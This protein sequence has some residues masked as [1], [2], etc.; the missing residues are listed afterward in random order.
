MEI[1]KK[2][3]E[4][5]LLMKLPRKLGSRKYVALISF[6]FFVVFFLC[7]NFLINIIAASLQG[8]YNHIIALANVFKIDFKYISQ[9]SIIKFFYIILVIIDLMAALKLAYNIRTSFYDLNIGQK[10]T[11]RFTS[12]EEIK[13]QYVRIP[14]KSMEFNGKAGI[15]VSMIEN[16]FYID[17]SNTNS[18]I[19]GMT[20]SGKGEMFVIPFI[21]VCS[22]S[23][24]KPS[25]VITDMKLEL[26]CRAYNTLKKRGYLPLL[27]NIE[28]PKIG[29]QYNPLALIIESYLAGNI[30]DAEMLCNTFAHNIYKS[31]SDKSNDG[32]NGKFFVNNASSAVSALILAHVDDCH[33]QDKR[34]NAKAEVL[35]LQ[36]Q[37]AYE[38]LADELKNKATKKWLNEKPESFTKENISKFAYIPTSERFEKTH[39][40][41]KKVT[42]P[43]VVH[44]FSDLAQKW[45]DNKT[46]QLDLY[47][48][49]RP[50]NDR[51]K[52]IYSSISVAGGERTKGS[53]FSQALT[54]LT[55]YMYSN[56][57][58]L[59]QRST[60]NL[61]DLGFGDKPIALFVGV[62]YYDRSKDSIV[63]TLIDQIFFA[64]AKKASTTKERKFKRRIFYHIDEAGN[65]TI[66][67]ITSKVSVGLGIGAIFN[68]FFQ[69]DSQITDRY[70]ENAAKTIKGNMGNQIYIQSSDFETAESFSKLLGPETI[71]SLNR[72]G[73]KFE[74]SKSFTE[75]QEERMLL[76]ANELMELE[77]GENV[78]KRYMKRT[79]LRGRKVK[80]YPIFNSIER[81][82]S[83]KYAYEYLLDDYP[84]DIGVNELGIEIIEDRKIEYFNYNIPL[85]KF[86]CERV[87]KIFKSGNQEE[88]ENLSPEDI[89]EY[90]KLK[91]Y[92][93]YD[94]KVG[95]IPNFSSFIENAK[96]AGL[97]VYDDMMLCDFIDEVTMSSL[98]IEDKTK[99]VDKQFL[100]KTI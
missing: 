67:D 8:K 84:D 7:G 6:I 48:Q 76:S 24:E 80:P 35:F 51:A 83:F 44:T 15:P 14:E 10:G 12:V 97:K 1:R 25:I 89:G 72:T 87:D 13:E 32:E 42:V 39:E 63:S 46:T 98:S 100:D 55:F 77:P 4:N 57:A 2:P 75:M 93:L 23:S 5:N 66:P 45:L 65:Y 17:T 20:R 71:T 74:L 58:K 86:A 94:E 27:L 62:P 22:R 96:N 38:K 50:E 99:L 29:I 31:K 21:D 33:M 16:S 81:G 88:I 79:D 59:T 49:N 82:T 78:I 19:I 47:F 3:G 92:F 60:F 40:N 61:T 95:D 70:G 34:D 56:I 90:K 91:K 69:N 52:Y 37:Q 41:I 43:S 54:E 30:D 36:A 73:K 18:L 26:V 28:D 64:N 85:N 9:S 68:M 53:I 11:S